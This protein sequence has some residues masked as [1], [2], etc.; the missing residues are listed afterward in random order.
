MYMSCQPAREMILQES[1]VQVI[2][3]MLV[4]VVMVIWTVNVIVKPVKC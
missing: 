1:T 4:M 2:V 3:V